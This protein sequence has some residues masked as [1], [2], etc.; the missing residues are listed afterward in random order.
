VPAEP[1]WVTHD[2]YEGLVETFD[3]P[4]L[5]EG[6]GELVPALW[7][8]REIGEIVPLERR[9]VDGFRHLPARKGITLRDYGSV[10]ELPL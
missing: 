2:Y 7:S 8:A 10:E 3:F 6:Y 5:P 9:L 1:A 4:L